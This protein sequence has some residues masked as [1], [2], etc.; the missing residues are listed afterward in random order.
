MATIKNLL[1]PTN[2]SSASVST[3]RKYLS[4]FVTNIILLVTMYS[5]LYS[6]KIS[7][8]SKYIFFLIPMLLI[9]GSLLYNIL[10]TKSND[11]STIV[12]AMLI[13]FVFVGS[14]YQFDSTSTTLH[15]QVFQYSTYLVGVLCIFVGLA[16]LTN[17]IYRSLRNMS[18]IPG[19]IINFLLFLPCLINDFTEYIKTEFKLTPPT[20]YIL[21]ALEMLLISIFVTISYIPRLAINLGGTTIVSD[22]K[23]LDS[24]YVY[25]NVN[26]ITNSDK[27]NAEKYDLL[28]TREHSTNRY[29]ISLWTYVNQRTHQS[30]RN[31]NIFSYGSDDSWKPRIEFVGAMN[32]HT[33]KYKDVYRITFASG[34]S[35]EVEIDSQKW[36]NFV[37]NYNGDFVDLFIN[38]SLVRSFE[39]T[40][41][42]NITTDQLIIGD[43]NGVYG[44]ICNVVYYNLPLT[45]REITTAY[46]LLN[47]RNPPINNI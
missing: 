38:G 8:T 30:N 18:G 31:V 5:V 3:Y 26:E 20:V 10:S 21:F 7:S 37:F 6:G 17:G 13:A 33:E 45:L 16:M 15:D 40:P 29:A 34:F 43:E 35:Y 2:D 32:T 27:V 39:C 14:V 1:A 9:T 11:P 22:A 41:G 42:Y 44:A 36:N 46:N 28:K 24:K 23:F 4:L 25:K 12:I 19:F 47:G